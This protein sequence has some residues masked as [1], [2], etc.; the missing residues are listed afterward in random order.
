MTNA[1]LREKRLRNSSPNPRD[2]DIRFDRALYIREVQEYLRRI[3]PDST[4]ALIPDG[5]FGPETAAAVLRFQRLVAIEETGIID[6]ITWMQIVEAAADLP[7][8]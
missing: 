1:Q 7:N 5:V 3:E 6:Y 2:N 4:I 8:E